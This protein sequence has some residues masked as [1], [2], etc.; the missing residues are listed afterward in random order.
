MIWNNCDCYWRHVFLEQILDFTMA[1][2]NQNT[3]NLQLELFSRE[4]AKSFR[5]R[6]LKLLPIPIF[7][8]TDFLNNVD[9]ADADKSAQVHNP[10]IYF[11][12]KHNIN[13]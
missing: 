5:Y 6:F 11:I 7:A 8:N 1:L 10:I 4:S 12:H 2:W 13:S 9:S 3:Y